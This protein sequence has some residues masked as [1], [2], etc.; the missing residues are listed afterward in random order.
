MTV[1]REK[2]AL[3]LGKPLTMALVMG[4]SAVLDDGVSMP[5]LMRL[6]MGVFFVVGAALTRRTLRA[7]P[8][9]LFG[10]Y[11]SGLSLKAMAVPGLPWLA[12]ASANSC[13]SAALRS[14]SGLTV[15]PAFSAG[16][17]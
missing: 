3:T 15:L 11:F 14:A 10:D 9:S 13:A 5:S 16:S 6:V 1:K 2:C 4:S 7:G 17:T 12:W 8:C